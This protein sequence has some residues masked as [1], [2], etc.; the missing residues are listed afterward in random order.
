MQEAKDPLNHEAKTHFGIDYIFPFQ[1]LVIANILRSAGVKGFEVDDDYHEELS[2][3]QIVLLP[4]GSGKSLCFMLPAF[5]LDGITLVVFP[6]LS[7]MSDQLRRANEAGL[8]AVILRGGQSPDDRKSIFRKCR[9]GNIKMILTNPETL[10]N[11]DVLDV[12]REMMIS[13][14]VIDEA[15]T[16]SEWGDSFR[17]AYLETGKILNEIDVP[18]VTAFTATASPHI[19]NRI[20]SVLFPNDTPNVIYGNPDRSNI[21]Y[22]VIKSASP[23]QTL[24]RK[25]KE[26]DKPAIVFTSSRTSTELTARMLRR[27]LVSKNVFFYHAGLEKPEKE[28]IESWFFHSDDGILVSTTAYGMGV[29]KS[30]I[31]TVIHLEPPPT[32]ESY[33]QESGRAGRDRDHAEALLIYNSRTKERLNKILDEHSAERFKSMLHYGENESSCRREYLLKLLNSAPEICSGCDICRD[34]VESEEYEELVMSIITANKRRFTRKEL[35]FFL[36][37]YK[38][39][40]IKERLL[41]CLWGFGIFYQWSTEMLEELVDSMIYTGVLRLPQKGI[42]KHRIST[43][44]SKMNSAIIGFFRS[45]HDRFR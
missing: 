44:R 4:T 31:R 45:F 33:L 23:N 15:H 21:S 35:V 13:H 25:I 10:Q 12:L 34:A 27:E 17:P 37:G 7:L 5:L 14:L 19:L 6:L 32:V 39:P 20:K 41:H 26:L 28:K 1:R 38:T 43:E 42:G 16:V 36:K 8:D 3:R 30:N 18:I 29:D 22:S 24:L 9:V 2:P 11:R 40:H